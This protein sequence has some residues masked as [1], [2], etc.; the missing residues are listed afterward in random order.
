MGYVQ[1]DRFRAKAGGQ[2]RGTSKGEDVMDSV[3]ALKRPDDYTAK[4]GA[5]FENK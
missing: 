2:Q 5:R 1:L 4:Q 3:I